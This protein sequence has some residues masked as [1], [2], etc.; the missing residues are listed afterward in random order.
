MGVNNTEIWNNLA[1]CCFYSSQY[2]MTLSCFERAL[3]LADD[4]SM[5]DVW[6]NIAQVAI[7]VG[8]LNLAY[9]S[10]K[11]AVSIDN[12]HAESYNNLGVLELRQENIEEAKSCFDTA[13]KLGPFL[14]EPLFNS[15]LLSYKMGN[16]QEA[17]ALVNRVLKDVYPEHT[18]SQELQRKLKQHFI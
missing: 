5:A 12:T 4:S 9:Q 17:F 3:S 1:L 15:A 14:H 7:G 16:H 18:D 6:Y 10:F 13:I 8:D 11:V 2:D